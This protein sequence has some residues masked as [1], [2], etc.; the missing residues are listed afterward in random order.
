MPYGRENGGYDIRKVPAE[1]EEGRV[2]PF[3][4]GGGWMETELE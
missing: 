2:F 3:W 1:W 4:P